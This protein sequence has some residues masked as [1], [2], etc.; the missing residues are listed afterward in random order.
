[1]DFI[2][3]HAETTAFLVHAE[4]MPIAR[5]ALS[6]LDRPP[7]LVETGAPQAFAKL[8]AFYRRS[9]QEDWE[10]RL[11][12]SGLAIAEFRVYDFNDTGV[13]FDTGLPSMERCFTAI[14]TA[15]AH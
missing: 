9:W 15:A 4:L 7:A 11:T 6:D 3:E 2:L 8:R 10:P 1:M 14:P 12:P 13:E 5:A